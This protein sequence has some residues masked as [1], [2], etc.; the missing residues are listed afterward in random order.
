VSDIVVMV[1]DLRRWGTGRGVFKGRPS[2]HLTVNGSTPE[3]LES[4][5]R[6][7]QRAG[8]ERRWFQASPPASTPHY[9]LTEG[10]RAAALGNGAV[11]VTARD[12]A[13]M[14][15]HARKAGKP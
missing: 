11:Y 13:A 14:R 4:L 6:V 15:A 7:A 3:H 9:D 1:D 10:K 12:Q 8:L 5:H 2:C